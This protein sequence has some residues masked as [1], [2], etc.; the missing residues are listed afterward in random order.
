MPPR[1]SA[2]WHFQID[3]KGWRLFERDGV[4][5]FALILADY[6]GIN[7]SRSDA[8]VSKHLRHHIHIYTQRDKDGGE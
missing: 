6:F 4:G 8:T 7:L 2:R 3:L 1:I 5:G